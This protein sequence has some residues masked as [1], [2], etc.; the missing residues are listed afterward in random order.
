MTSG[1][2][3]LTTLS[4]SEQ[5][6]SESGRHLEILDVTELFATARVT[7]YSHKR[8]EVGTAHVNSLSTARDGARH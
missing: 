4:D 2:S 8:R 6:D 7:E 1:C 5:R 3:G